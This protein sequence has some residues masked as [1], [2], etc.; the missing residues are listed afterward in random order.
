MA[1]TPGGGVVSGN[2]IQS[3]TVQAGA[4]DP[5]NNF[6]L[7]Q[8]ASLNG[9][10]YYDQDNAGFKDAN[11]PGI[12]TVTVTLSGVDDRGA[13][14]NQTLATAGNGA[15]GF[16]NLRPG[17]YSITESPPQG[18]LPGTNN[19]GTLNGVTTGTLSGDQFH[20]NVSG[21]Q[22]GQNYNFGNVLPPPP[23]VPPPVV[24]PPVVPPPVVPPPVVPPP[25]VPPPVVP[26]PVVPPPV[27]PPPVV[28]PPV[29]PPPVVPPPP[30]VVPPPPPVVPPPPPPEFILP[31]PPPPISK[32][33][34][35][36]NGWMS[37]D[38]S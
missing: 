3:I 20:I 28:P 11:D 38:W 1:G 7:V 17:S 26:P 10:V 31:S 12:S 21:G 5:N 15:Y 22:T 27:V 37:W 29:V 25:V 16:A 8:I 23:V 4:S 19:I 34:L 14:V 13:S 18:Y 2:S 9:F 30:P 6:G 33:D 24:P 36:G 35:T 32:R